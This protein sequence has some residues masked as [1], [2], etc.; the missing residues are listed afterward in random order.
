MTFNKAQ[1]LQEAQ[2]ALAQGKLS[3]AIR[4]YLSIV[5][6]DPS[7]LSLLNTVGDLCVRDNNLNEALRLFHKLAE[8]YVREGFLL[9]AIAI[10]KKIIKLDPNAVDPLLKLAALYADQ[11]LSREAR[12][13][14]AQALALCQR[15]NQ[16][17]RAIE[18]MRKMVSSEPANK[19]HLFRLAECCLAIGRTEEA[20]KAYLDGAVC[21]LGEGDTSSATVALDQAATINPLDARLAELRRRISPEPAPAL[22][23]VPEAAAEPAMLS[24]PEEQPAEIQSAEAVAEAGSPAMAEAGP[25]PAAVPEAAIPIREPEE[26]DLSEE[27]EAIAGSRLP[28]PQPVP[29]EAALPEAVLPEIPPAEGVLPEI[30][31]IEAVPPEVIP[32]KFDFEEAAAE[33]DFYLNY[34]LAQ[35]AQKAVAKLEEKFPG[36]PKVAELRQR[37][38]ADRGAEGEIA[39]IPAGP[40]TQNRVAELAKDLEASWAGIE[41]APEK[42][43]SPAM[44]AP[45]VTTPDFSVSL[46]ALLGELGAEPS[47]V[48]QDD[49]QT[50]YQLGVAFREMGLTEEAIGE[51]QKVV[52]TVGR[53]PYPPQYL[54]ACSLL[55]LCFM[56]K[57]LPKLA[58]HWY[59]RALESPGL[60]PDAAV[61]LEYD[62]GAALEQAGDLE[63]AREKFLQVYSQ[64]V[65]YR[66]VAEKVRQLASKS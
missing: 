1:A 35:E 64:N 16:K 10:Y 23:E 2:R 8:A 36:D 24:Q 47:G 32:P 19:A 25:T 21:A 4:E 12:D 6:N 39:E 40:S 26:F 3:Q 52:R 37:L 15:D 61:A 31:P 53:G 66:D 13:L 20:L 33:I 5:E 14:Y 50:H 34:G 63:A 28:L 56:D 18:V 22:P 59:T 43:V 49:L 48:S 38:Q 17:E 65:D 51:F 42:S 57:R 58:V 7:D 54:A 62:L 27:W 45:P 9:R 11:G 41:S 46:S 29:P 30:A 55:G 60:D 44:P